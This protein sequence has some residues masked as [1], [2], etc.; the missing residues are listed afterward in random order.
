M[1]FPVPQHAGNF[2]TSWRRQDSQE[3][4]CPIEL[5]GF[6]TGEGQNTKLHARS[7]SLKLIC[8]LKYKIWRKACTEDRN[9]ILEVW[10]LRLSFVIPQYFNQRKQV[11]LQT[12]HAV[13]HLL[14]CTPPLQSNISERYLQ[15]ARYGKIRPSGNATDKRTDG[16]SVNCMISWLTIIELENR[17][18]IPS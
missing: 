10:N 4:P 13:N 8:S 12:L 18:D 11:E 14:I 5:G 9:R 17:F 3:G 2:L 16:T 1:N 7:H 15:G 6:Q